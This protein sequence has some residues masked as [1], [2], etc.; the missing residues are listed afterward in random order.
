MDKNS[1]DSEL[2]FVESLY[3]DA[4]EQLKEIYIEE[5][6]NRDDLLQEI[7]KIL[8]TYTIVNDI[9]SMSKKERD[10]E[11]IRLSKI[12]TEFSKNQAKTTE[13][14]ITDILTNTVNNTYDYY[15]YNAK[16]KDVKEI[17]DSNYKGKHF[18]DRVWDNEQAVAKH[19]HLQTQEFL[20]GNIDVNKIKKNIETTFNTSAYNAKRLTETEISRCQNSAFDR[21][22]IETNV[23]RL[24]YVATLDKRL[25]SDCSQY[26]D[27]IFDFNN[28][29]E[30]PR[31]PMCR[32]F[33]TIE[34]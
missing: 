12:I 28:K 25:C 34:S 17:I 5:K 1:Y 26:H 30:L 11:Y 2:D 31:H 8:L 15:S 14:V 9:M 23:K 21:F 3:N 18:S 16:L 29:I 32:C 27:K 7:G 13:K 19:L 10:K 24:R 6:Q 33:Y 4:D 22:C 20:K